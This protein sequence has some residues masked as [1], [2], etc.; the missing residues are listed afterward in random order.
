[1]SKALKQIRKYWKT[2][3]ITFV[4]ALAIGA[5]IFCLL[6]FLRDK[7]LFDAVNG[8]SIAAVSVLFVGLLMWVSHLGAFDTIVFGFKRSN[9]SSLA[10]YPIGCSGCCDRD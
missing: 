8:A 1:M 4:I 10:G 6:F 7:S 3:L 5:I 9:G 2:N